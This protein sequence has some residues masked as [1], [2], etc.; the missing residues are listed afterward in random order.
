[1]NGSRMNLN[2]LSAVLSYCPLSGYFTWKS[3]R[4]GKARAGSLAGAIDSKGYVQIKINGKLYLAHRLAWFYAS[5]QWPDSHIDHI[6]RNPKNNAIANLRL[7]SHAEN[8]QNIDVRSDNSSGVTGVSWIKKSQK[9]LAYINRNGVR[10]R[11]GLFASIDS[12]VAARLEAKRQI[13]TFHP[14]QSGIIL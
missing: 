12:A 9:W 5:G 13:H 1:M 10:H 6:D 2:E 8:H 4:G 14:K 7:C 3:F 11:I